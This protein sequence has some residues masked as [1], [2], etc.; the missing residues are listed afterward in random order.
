VVDDIVPV[1]EAIQKVMR[2]NAEEFRERLSNIENAL[3]EMRINSRRTYGLSLDVPPFVPFSEAASPNLSI[4]SSA[5]GSS[6]TSSG[7]DISRMS[8]ENQESSTV[9][10]AS[11]GSTGGAESSGELPFTLQ[12]GRIYQ[13]LHDDI[14]SSVVTLS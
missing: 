4:T 9:T 12:I 5:A 14:C 11:G 2:A 7:A 8:L 1:L 3:E 10:G 13:C 6:S